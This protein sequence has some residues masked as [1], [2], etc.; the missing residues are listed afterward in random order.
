MKKIAKVSGIT[1]LVLLGILLL[2]AIFLVIASPGKAQPL[3]NNEN[4]PIQGSLS[5]KTWVEIGSVK[6][7]MFIR[8]DDENKPVLLFLHGGPGSPEFCIEPNM[9]EGQRLEDHFTV[10]YWDQR[11]AGM[12][13]SRTKT[14]ES[15]TM[16]T[17]VN[18]TIEVTNYLR[19]RFN[20][21]KIFILGHSWGSLLGIKTIQKSPELYEA[22]IGTGQVSDQAQSELLAYDYM[23][24]HAKQIGD[25]KAVKDLEKF[26][27]STK[28]YLAREYTFSARTHYMNKYGI[29]MMHE[30]VS[31]LEMVGKIITFKGYTA[32]EK[33]N[34]LS[35][36]S[37][38]QSEKLFDDV[39]TN[40]LIQSA[41]DL[42]VP[43]YILQGIYDYQ[44]SYE[45]AKQY[46]EAI[47]APDKA[48]YSFENSA[49]SP[50]FEEPEKFN[51]IMG[52][53]ANKNK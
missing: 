24:E 34:Y 30:D 37:S 2:A 6:Q 29:G 23:L 38:K 43:V 20:K 52:E 36:I 46:Y 28:E 33:L 13:Y 17:M 35:G 15:I 40:N 49:H 41:T 18:D 10:C 16:D 9:P 8:T 45:L 32:F 44:V 5:E 39:L 3:L 42:K 48:F 1:I 50:I 19:Q 14:N 22:Y 11:G 25:K 12:S 27:R 4:K 7:G 51:Q 31:M 53:I 47:Q 26:D 21:D